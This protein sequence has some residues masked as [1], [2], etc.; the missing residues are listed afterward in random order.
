MNNLIEDLKVKY[1]YLQKLSLEGW[2][3][4]FIRRNGEYLK[5]YGELKSDI[6]EQDFIEAKGAEFSWSEVNFSS[7]AI[8]HKF[9]RLQK[10]FGICPHL[11]F[12]P[13]DSE[14]YLSKEINGK[15]Y[16]VSIP[17]PEKQYD[18]IDPELRI[19][20]SNPILSYKFKEHAVKELSE[21]DKE[22]IYERCYKTINRIS[23]NLDIPNTLYIG[24]S[25]NAKKTEVEKALKKLLS[26]PDMNTKK[27]RVR[28]KEWKYYLIVYDLYEFMKERNL[29]APFVTIEQILSQT[30]PKDKHKFKPE[31]IEDYYNKA[32]LLIEKNF[33]KYF[34][35]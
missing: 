27:E 6:S 33:K 5:I 31:Y 34:Y 10:G 30:Y 32:Y 7:R 4:E 25:L 14:S 26:S 28:P 13:T 15:T 17:N 8:A 29:I 20:G 1:D 2:L 22:K 35:I 12:Y 18:K 3:W 16:F 24:I 21:G 23:P 11:Y 19:R 9:D